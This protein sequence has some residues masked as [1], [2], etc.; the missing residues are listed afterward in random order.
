[1]GATQ[2]PHAAG[3]DNVPAVLAPVILVG[4]AQVATYVPPG[5][6]DPI[7]TKFAV[8]LVV[9]MVSLFFLVHALR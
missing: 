5:I 8:V 3:V 2:A 6:T 9:L 7:V 4:Q 1:M